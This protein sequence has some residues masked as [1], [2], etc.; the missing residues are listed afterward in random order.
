[1]YL[2]WLGRSGLVGPAGP[3]ATPVA[4]AQPTAPPA[5]GPIRLAEIA[6]RGTG[7]RDEDGDEPDWVELANVD[8]EPQSLAGYALS[9]DPE[10]PDK[11]RLPSLELLPGQRLVV[12]ASGKDRPTAPEGSTVPA[13]LRFETA[14]GDG[15]EWRY[16][17]GGDGLP[18]GWMNRD[19]DDSGWM[20]GSTGI[21]Y[22]DDDDT[23]TVPAGTMSVMART[24]VSIPDLTHVGA[25]VLSMDYDD[26]FV[27]YLNGH[28]IAR[29]GLLGRPPEWSELAPSTRRLSTGT[30]SLMDFAWSETRCSPS[31]WR[32]TT[33]W[34]CRCTTRHWTRRT[35][36]CGLSC[37]LA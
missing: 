4:T 3:T 11:W 30:A 32:A 27:A 5:P 28:E 9:D 12:F 22:G 6:P 25:L 29:R 18:P 8:A 35:L 19:F 14:L 31:W 37:T 24:L 10:R 13:R 2:P 33:Y 16:T 21:G 26:G 17:I 15:H 20:V 34:R 1:V 23:T 36:R 7:L